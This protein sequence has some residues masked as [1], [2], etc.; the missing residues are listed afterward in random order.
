MPWPGV[1]MTAGTLGAVGVAALFGKGRQRSTT[2]R[3]Q[4][5]LAARSSPMPLPTQV[6]PLPE[7]VERYFRFARVMEHH[8]TGPVQLDEEGEFRL[9][10]EGAWRPF[11]AV[12]YIN[13]AGPAFLWD[14]S[15]RLFPGIRLMV[16]DGYC[17]GV[18]RLEARLAGIVPLA[19]EEND[20]TLAAGELHRYLA[21]AV[22]NPPAL[23]PESGIVWDPIDRDSA[24]ATL[25][26]KG[27]TVSLDFLFDREGRLI[28]AFSRGRYRDVG[29]EPVLTPWLCEYDDY[30]RFNRV[31]VPREGEVG[32]LLPQGLV[33]YCRLR[34]TR[35]RLLGAR[36][37]NEA[38]PA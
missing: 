37:A 21:E 5:V 15:I 18:G 1:A 19:H 38:L 10:L 36:N 28:K 8:A 12:Q 25:T 13:P 11:S 27:V 16:E 2:R 33:S 3:V 24:R 30:A 4:A 31:M 34:V 17:G 14:A 22:W 35:I 7:P 20:T 29:G 6:A 32:W 23:R 26:V 9:G